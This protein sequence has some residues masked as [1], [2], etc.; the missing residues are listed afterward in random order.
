M[1]NEVSLKVKKIMDL[2]FDEAHNYYDSKLRVEHVLMG[3]LIDNDNVCTKS[4]KK[5]SANTESLY[6]KVS[7]YLNT[8]NINP[9]L[10]K[11][12]KV[13]PNEEASKMLRLA[14]LEKL[15]TDNIE[16]NSE[17]LLL[18]ILSFENQASKILN[19]HNVNYTNFKNTIMALSDLEDDVNDINST[20]N[21]SAKFKGKTSVSSTP[22][23][24][25]FCRDITKMA[26]E[27][28]I[29]Q[30]VGRE[31][32]IKRMTQILSKKGKKNPI[33]LGV[34]GCG[35]SAVVEGLALMISNRTAPRV[36][37][38]KKIY[39]LDI[40]SIV[41]GTK[42]RG[43]FE[44]R[45]KL[46]INEAKENPQIIIFIDEI[47][48]IVGTGNSSGGL[49]VSNILKP[50]LARGDLQVIGATTLDEYRENIEKDKA[51]SRRFQQVMIDEPTFDETVIILNNI[52]DKF[53]TYHKVIYS[54]EV[55]LEC[56]KLADRYI[57]D[58]AMPDKAIDIL[59][60]V[61]ASTN[62]SLE[63]PS[64]IID[65]ERAVLEVKNKKKD[66]V[67]KQE[68]EM[69]AKLRDEENLL[70]TKLEKIKNNWLDKL[71]TEKTPISVDMVSTIV[72]NMTGIP[73]SKTTTEENK[74]LSNMESD[75]N[76]IVIGQEDAVAKISKGIRRS[77][78]KVRKTL[79]PL[80]YILLGGTGTGKTFLTKELAR[81]VYGGVDNMIRFDMS[82]F[83]EKHSISKLIGS[84]A[85]Y[86][87]YEE[88][89]KL[90][91]AVK[92]KPYSVVLFDEIEKAHP[93]IFNILL[94]VLDEGRL[95]DS[96]GKTIDF[97]NTIIILTSNIGVAELANFGSGVGFKTST[98]VLME[99]ENK[100][101]FLEKAMK[102]KF[103]PEFLNRIDEIVIFN[104]LTEENIQ[105]IIVNEIN[106]VSNGLLELGYNL[107][108]SKL[109]LEFIAKEGYH[110][111]YGA[112]PLKRAIQ[113]LVEDPITDELLE[114][115]VY[116][117][118]TL[119]VGL[120]KEGDKIVIS[121]EKH[122]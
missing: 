12:K 122:K 50:A 39:E 109:A 110:K 25:G 108:V 22:V 58:R 84:P 1:P 2:A 89:G 74:K 80:S 19:N 63:V 101:L 61:G 11:L 107:K 26:S 71:K 24:D 98:S 104:S 116:K 97:K 44:E 20:R 87:G 10:T 78:L 120:N 105:R 106:E 103:A 28:K 6:N 75:L 36:L 68:Y 91:E 34:A 48:T 67:N 66:I 88:G 31:K 27:G 17:H 46:I 72:S 4:F 41:S 60:E 14:E 115:K 77:K 49:D 56:V 65:L 37:L 92:N 102:K 86:V 59:D 33:L 114:E 45:M 113:R 16:L 55:V 3:I 100:K 121:I 119:K 99:E 64:E 79:R 54:K 30:V 43:M 53:E 18:S 40:N 15:K 42:Y 94:Q 96:L 95:T 35:K 112:R 5:L 83:M 117:G 32:E 85:G 62:I 73:I 13:P 8:V 111:E 57:T 70:T 47:H 9:K 90:T 118:D 21:N 82:E 76:K 7:E 52:K 69:A 29:D 81:M 38:D 51:L 93:D 23:L